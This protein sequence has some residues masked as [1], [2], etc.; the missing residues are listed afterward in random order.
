MLINTVLLFLS[1]SLVI[2]MILA[3]LM[4]VKIKFSLSGV[5][6]F[7]GALIGVFLMLVLWLCIDTISQMNEGTGLEWFY[8]VIHLIVYFLILFFVRLLNSN[9]NENM[10]KTQNN[11]SSFFA[12]TIFS[13]VIMLQGTNF[14]IYFIG[15][16]SHENAINTLFI[17]IIL[18]AGICISISI[19]L[20]FLC[21]YLNERFYG[22]STEFILILFS[23]GLINKTSDLLLQIDSLPSTRMIF[24][25]NFIVREK[26]EFG[27]FLKALFGY[28]ASPTI[29]QVGLYFTALLTAF[30]LCKLP[31]KP[32]RIFRLKDVIS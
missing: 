14:I 32:W 20:Y 24:D 16:W 13:L 15:Y 27:Y 25:L 17:G 3:L 6:L 19:L 23:C 31:K 11:R 5:A 28:D 30:I 7:I 29:L 9:T 12:A 18:G 10:Q 8:V 4:S 21:T 26:S 22:R 1:N 2:F